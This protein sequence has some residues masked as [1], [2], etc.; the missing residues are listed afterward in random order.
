MNANLSGKVAVVT[1]GSGALGS[2]MCLG[3]AASGA[4][5][6]I[7]A[8]GVEKAKSL[9][10]RIIAQ[11]HEAMAL[12][13]DVVEVESVSRCASQIATEFGPCDILVNAAGGNSPL[14]TTAKE[15]LDKDDVERLL[16]GLYQKPASG[17]SSTFFDLDPAGVRSVFDLNFM[18]TFIPTQAFS[19][20]MLAK[21]GGAII[22]IASMGSYAPMTKVPAYCA[23]KAAIVNF[24]EWLAVHFAPVGIRVNAI[25]PGFFL[26]E[27]NRKLLQGEDGTLT[28]RGIK[29]IEHTPSGRFGL[30]EDLVGTLLWLCDGS[31]SRFVTGIVVPVD[32]GFNAYAGV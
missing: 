24:T 3:L 7:L 17:N 2:A 13:C 30:P 28:A 10:D 18:G 32:G 6:A 21:Q 16:A 26:G 29:I 25:A 1:G 14:A 15:R 22:N 27:Q 11:G 5:V 19:E 31:A 9:V 23:A 4:K 12:P 8:R 20:Q